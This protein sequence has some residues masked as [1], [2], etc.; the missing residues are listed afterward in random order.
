MADALEGAES[1]ISLVQRANRL[2]ESLKKAAVS[3]ERTSYRFLL[4][5]EPAHVLLLAMDAPLINQCIKVHLVEK[6]RQQCL[7]LAGERSQHLRIQIVDRWNA[8]IGYLDKQEFHLTLPATETRP[9]FEEI[10]RLGQGDSERQDSLQPRT[11]NVHVSAFVL[12]GDCRQIFMRKCLGKF[13]RSS[14]KDA[15]ESPHLDPGKWDRSIGGHL[16]FGGTP[17]KELSDEVVHHLASDL[18][19]IVPEDLNFVDFSDFVECCR[20][21]GRSLKKLARTHTKEVILASLGAP[22]R[23]TYPRKRWFVDA[24]LPDETIVEPV[25]SLPFLCLLPP[26]VKN[27]EVFPYRGGK[28]PGGRLDHSS[29]WASLK[30]GQVSD[31]ITRIQKCTG[32]MEHEMTL[33]T[34]VRTRPK[35]KGDSDVPL[36][37]EAVAF[38]HAYGAKLLGCMCD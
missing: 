30:H 17:R 11:W 23:C 16:L 27:S 38:F 10:T 4:G 19:P 26:E 34:G 36:T 22:F 9:T 25:L 8:R 14:S 29:G 24:N 31:L 15:D 12:S 2:I 1:P 20:D 33:P 13:S 35:R 32:K 6:W 37:W 18:W 21:R 3:E 28:V 7:Q 5:T